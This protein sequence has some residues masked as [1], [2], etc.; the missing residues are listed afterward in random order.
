[1]YIVFRKGQKIETGILA[2]KWL[3]QVNKNNT[4]FLIIHGFDKILMTL[5]TLYSKQRLY[6]DNRC[7]SQELNFLV[8]I[9]DEGQLNEIQQRLYSYTMTYEDVLSWFVMSNLNL[10]VQLSRPKHQLKKYKKPSAVC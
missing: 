8:I 9:M 3:A 5:M 10:A 1:M 7:T 2:T 4:N 6:C